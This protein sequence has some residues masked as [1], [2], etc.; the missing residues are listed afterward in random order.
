MRPP[1]SVSYRANRCTTTSGGGTNRE[2]GNK[3]SQTDRVFEIRS[4][5]DSAVEAAR[6]RPQ[7]LLMTSFAFILGVFP[8]VVAEGAGHEMRQ[9]RG[10]AVFYGMIGVTVSGHFHC[11]WMTP[12]ARLPSTSWRS[13]AKGQSHL[14]PVPM[15]TTGQA[16]GIRQSGQ[17][18]PF[19]WR[20][21]LPR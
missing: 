20:K 1:I 8:L 13:A 11:A 9:T 5:F 4:R 19:V 16:P 3:G 7:P 12:P 6:E 15:A 21:R 14:R 18:T 2:R 10:T 17:E